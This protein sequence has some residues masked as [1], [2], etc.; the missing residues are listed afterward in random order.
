MAVMAITTKILQTC[1]YIKFIYPFQTKG[2]TCFDVF[3]TL[4]LPFHYKSISIPKP[5][6]EDLHL[7]TLTVIPPTTGVDYT[8]GYISHC[9]QHHMALTLRSKVL[10]CALLLIT[11]AISSTYSL[12]KIQFLPHKGQTVRSVNNCYSFW[13]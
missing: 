11:G 6:R 13:E 12:F 9:Y 1:I 7:V 8:A 4:S 5:L 10:N 2:K 3:E